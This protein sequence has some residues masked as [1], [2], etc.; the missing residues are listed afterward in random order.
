M[1]YTK[2]NDGPNR[3][4]GPRTTAGKKR[5]RYNALKSG[6]FARTMPLDGESAA[7]LKD[8][9]RAVWEE[10]RPE[11]QSEMEE[12]DHLVDL[13]WQRRCLRRAKNAELAKAVTVSGFDSLDDQR[14]QAWDASR[15][16]K[17]EG[18]MLRH[19]R[20]PY[21][22]AEAIGML[23][24]FR[25][26]VDKSGLVNESGL[27]AED[28]WILKKLYGI[29]EDD[30]VPNG[31]FYLY[32]LHSSVA[33]ARK[34]DPV[35]KTGT[36]GKTNPEEKAATSGNTNPD[37]PKKRMLADID[38]ELE[39]LNELEA[40]ALLVDREREALENTA[41]LLPTGEV[42]D[43]SIRS[44]AHISREIDKTLNRLEKLQRRRKGQP[45]PPTL[46]VK[47]EE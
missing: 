47:L 41:A 7:E 25:K 35:Q 11:T 39:M 32:R 8:L 42:L 46:E 17:S 5:I 27:V 20:N 28:P 6:F 18:G 16:W 44:E 37:E 13:Y 29:D 9:H 40:T 31:L 24:T 3:A 33:T 45:E 2:S 34:T 38:R 10:E 15:N 14:C 1:S 22:L 30:A 19:I 43:R 4:T 23:N 12:V 21:V 36:P 26:M